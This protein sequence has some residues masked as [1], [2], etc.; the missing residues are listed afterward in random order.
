M[1]WDW[2]FEPMSTTPKNDPLALD[3][4]PL[5]LGPALPPLPVAAAS[6]G[7]PASFGAG[8]LERLCT[9]AIELWRMKTRLARAL[10]LLPAKEGRPFETSVAKLEEL[11]GEWGLSVEDPSGRPYVEGERLEVLLFEPHADLQRPTILQTVKPAVYRHGV[12][13]KQAQVIVGTP[14][15]AEKAP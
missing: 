6:P 14:Q 7:A 4:A 10:P 15:E 9:F 13:A 1:P 12:L 11:L 8:D 2:T 5:P 3:E